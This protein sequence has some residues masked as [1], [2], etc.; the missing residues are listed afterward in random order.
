[1]LTQTLQLTRLGGGLMAA[2]FTLA[3]VV[4]SAPAADAVTTSVT[5][6]LSASVATMPAG[7][8]VLPD[9]SYDS[10]DLNTTVAT[11]ADVPAGLSVSV[12]WELTNVG[13]S[14]RYTGSHNVCIYF[15]T[16]SNSG[17]SVSCD[18]GKATTHTVTV[19]LSASFPIADKVVSAAVGYE[20]DKTTSVDGSTTYSLKAHKSGYLW[21]APKMSHRLVTARQYICVVV[22]GGKGSCSLDTKVAPN[23]TYTKH[24]VAPI[25]G[26]HYDTAGGGGG[27]CGSVDVNGDETVGTPSNATVYGDNSDGALSASAALA[28]NTLDTVEL[29]PNVL[30]C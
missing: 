29:T 11:S 5:P 10:D 3:I 13:S 2:S 27:G 12:P 30:P 17:V 18:I 19:S 7:T 26:I 20:V 14:S 15:N 8:T 1:M 24:Y 4:F 21:W 25:M 28:S 22:D 16:G 23:T 9:G 6:P